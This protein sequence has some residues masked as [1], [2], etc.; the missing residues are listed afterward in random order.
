MKHIIIGSGISGLYLAY[1][2]IKEKNEISEN[3]KIYEKENRIGGR[4]YT[5]ENKRIIWNIQLVQ[6][7]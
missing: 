7:D 1:K 2:L 6:E 5:Y 3:I 4:I